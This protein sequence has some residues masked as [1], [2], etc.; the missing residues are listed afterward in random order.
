ML[1]DLTR[2]LLTVRRWALIVL[3]GCGLAGLAWLVW[4]WVG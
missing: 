2:K 4:R 1:D 3:A